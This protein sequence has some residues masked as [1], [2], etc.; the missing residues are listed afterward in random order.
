[1]TNMNIGSHGVI[2]PVG[3]KSSSRSPHPFWNTA[4]I[5]P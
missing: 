4:T 2:P 3:L 5:T 1:M